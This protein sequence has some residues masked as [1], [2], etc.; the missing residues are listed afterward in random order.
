MGKVKDPN[1]KT[2]VGRGGRSWCSSLRRAAKAGAVIIVEETGMPVTY[3][4]PDRKR[5]RPWV[6]P[7]GNRYDSTECVPDF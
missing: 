2:G 3:D 5:F 7:D 1:W 6:D 4:N